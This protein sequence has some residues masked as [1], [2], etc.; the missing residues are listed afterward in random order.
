ME[1]AAAS[2]LFKMHRKKKVFR[3]RMKKNQLAMR[4][5]AKINI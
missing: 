5:A 2:F 4:Q 1:K 3:P